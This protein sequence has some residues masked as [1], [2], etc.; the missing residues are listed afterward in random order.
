MNLVSDL[1]SRKR[2]TYED[3]IEF[4]NGDIFQKTSKDDQDDTPS[5]ESEQLSHRDQTSIMLLR[6]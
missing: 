5:S 3:L 2:D 4:D 1:Q 6:S